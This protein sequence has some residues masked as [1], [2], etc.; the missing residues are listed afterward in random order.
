MEDP[1]RMTTTRMPSRSRRALLIT[2]AGALTLAACSNS[3]D[4][5]ADTKAAATEAPAEVTTAA[6]E[7]GASSVAATPT[8]AAPASAAPGTDTVEVTQAAGLE[9]GLGSR[10]KGRKIVFVADNPPS[11]PFWGTIQRGAQDAAKLFNIEL[12]YQFTPEGADINGYNELIGTAVASKPDALAIV[13]R[14]P[15]VLTENIC[16]ASKAGIPV[17]AYNIGPAPGGGTDPCVLGFIGQDF[18]SAGYKVGKEMV[19]LAGIKKGDLVLLPVEQPDASYAVQ[20]GQGVKKAL[21]EVGAKYEVIQAGAKG[22]AEALEN[23]TQWLIGHP[24]VKAI[25]PMGGTPHRNAIQALKDAKLSP[26]DVK[27]GGFDISQPII[28]GIK[29]GEILTAVTQE[30]YIQGFQTVAEL[31]MLLDFGIYPFSI[32]TGAGLVNKDNAGVV[33]EL[34]GKVR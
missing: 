7:A 18:P 19:K 28:D 26:A 33:E 5:A 2:F 6:T 27:I 9:S 31:A 34:A 29:S 11:D 24:T 12:D 22:D 13:V 8:E 15:D 21:D 4:S 1:N 16:A 23:M 30:P 32:N 10:A 25:I 14:D 20:R 3:S 17:M